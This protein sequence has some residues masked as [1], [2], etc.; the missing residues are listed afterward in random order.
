[1]GVELITPEAAAAAAA[2]YKIAE[3]LATRVLGPTFDYFGK[4]TKERT[5][6][7]ITNITQVLRSGERKLGDRANTPGQ[8]PARVAKLIIE[9]GYFCD[10]ELAA[11]YFGGILAASRSEDGKDDRGLCFA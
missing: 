4:K 10:N 1:M 5:E 11:E 6:K 8:V 2:A 7:A 9:E 3:A